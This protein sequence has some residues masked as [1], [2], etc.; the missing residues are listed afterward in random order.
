M[1]TLTE[2]VWLGHTIQ[3]RLEEA[4][5]VG[6]LVNAA[7]SASIEGGDSVRAVTW[8]ET[9]RG[10]IWSQLASV[11]TPL[12]ALAEHHADLATALRKARHELQTLQVNTRSD[13]VIMAARDNGI[14]GLRDLY[15]ESATH[16]YQKA[17]TDHDGI[18]KKIRSCDG[19]EDILRPKQL[20]VFISS[21]M[22]GR[23][24][25]TLVFIN[26][27]PSSCGALLLL[28]TG[29]VK[30][31]K[32]P[33]LSQ[34]RAETMRNLWID[35]I[36]LRRA[37]RRRNCHGPQE[38]A[39]QLRASANMYHRILDRLWTWVVHPILSELKL[40]SDAQR[41]RT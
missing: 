12:D 26:V 17:V 20:S 25:G 30:L 24:S 10:L 18:L 13:S 15:T 19:F 32:L 1:D 27:A 4:T 39:T 36:G 28:P 38:R 3:R 21:P 14:S 33:A 7:V 23:L 37:S 8:L 11:H 9:G 40:V 16:Q 2:L 6:C 29:S 31:V 41:L 5:R 22:F 35:A 34:R